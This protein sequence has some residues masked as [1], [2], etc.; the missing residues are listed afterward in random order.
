MLETI[1]RWKDY[2]WVEATP[3]VAQTVFKPK[4]LLRS[5]AA[6]MQGT[7]AKEGSGNPVLVDA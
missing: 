1:G 7:L 2:L 4:P 6:V 3:R 5:A